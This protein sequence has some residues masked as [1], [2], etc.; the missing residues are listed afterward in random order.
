[1][2]VY[3]KLQKCR[4]ELQAK[5]LKKSGVN[6]F[7]GFSYYE[8]A[9]FIPTI[10]KL[11]DDI[12][13]CS[14]F[15]ILGDMASLEI[16]NCEKPEEK[17]IFNS[18][19]AD[20]NLKGCTPVQSLGGVHTYLKRY[21]YLNALEIVESDMLDGNV[22]KP[23]SK[24]ATQ[25]TDYRQLLVDYCKASGID[26]KDIAVEYKLNSKSSQADFRKA[27]EGVNNNAKRNS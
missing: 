24:P 5:N 15:S 16:I 7:A 20:A 22:N 10:N 23:E 8:L 25:E 12:G 14:N 21:L 19:I 6:K 26:M 27:L 2:N 1:M 18:P 3:Q 17:I 13:L 4:V 11:F 9:D